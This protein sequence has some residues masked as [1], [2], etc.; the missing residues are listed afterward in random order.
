MTTILTMIVF[1]VFFTLIIF[2]RKFTKFVLLK[3]WITVA[4]LIIG[5]VV[6]V[7]AF[8]KPVGDTEKIEEKDATALNKQLIE[9]IK[10]A[11]T[12][13]EDEKNL[14]QQFEFDAPS[15]IKMKIPE[16]SYIQVVVHQDA[17]IE[18][19]RVR[20]FATDQVFTSKKV[21]NSMIKKVS[22]AD[23]KLKV[24][25]TDDWDRLFILGSTLFVFDEVNT[26]EN[27]W[28]NKQ[29]IEITVP[30][31]TTVQVKEIE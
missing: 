11:S 22:Y 30:K 20:V 15:K 4:V 16:D 8:V 5:C 9:R 24:H 10:T 17:Q 1:L 27:E 6:Y 12:T 19:S 14:V 2:Q 18:K 21:K 3:S 7:E 26:E 13:K 25:N 23:G 28:N 31:T 29:I